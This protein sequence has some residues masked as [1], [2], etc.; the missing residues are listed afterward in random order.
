VFK[1]TEEGLLISP[2]EAQLMN[3]L[4]EISEGLKARGVTLEELIASGREIR[5]EIYN[6][7]YV[8]ESE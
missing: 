1:E 8:P 6:E 5:Q 4:E 2:K 7:K 3:L